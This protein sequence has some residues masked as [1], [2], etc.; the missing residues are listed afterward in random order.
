MTSS[1]VSAIDYGSL[2]RIAA[3]QPRSFQDLVSF[4]SQQVRRP[5]TRWLSNFPWIK[6]SQIF[7]S[8][9]ETGGA[10]R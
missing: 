10:I 3:N 5:Q 4:L 8:S 9:Q 1:G 2:N 6:C 7:L